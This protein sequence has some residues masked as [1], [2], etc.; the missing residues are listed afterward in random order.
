VRL[1]GYLKEIYY[2][3]QQHGC[4]LSKHVGNY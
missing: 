3:A 4:K 1:F 2:A